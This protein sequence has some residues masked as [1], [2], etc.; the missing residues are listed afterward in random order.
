MKLFVELCIVS[1]EVSS[2]EPSEDSPNPTFIIAEEV[3]FKE[4][5]AVFEG[6]FAR[7][8]DDSCNEAVLKVGEVTF[9]AMTVPCEALLEEI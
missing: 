9:V 6:T 1:F 3:T 2:A 8:V 7:S 4:P 5:E